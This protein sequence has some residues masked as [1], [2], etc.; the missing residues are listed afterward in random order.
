V[1]RCVVKKEL[2]VES[3]MVVVSVKLGM[4]R[5]S[6]KRWSR[7]ECCVVNER[8]ESKSNKEHG[9]RDGRRRVVQ[10]SSTK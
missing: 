9:E 8:V 1:G 4:R 3:R 10:R 7:V 2:R 5:S 6:S